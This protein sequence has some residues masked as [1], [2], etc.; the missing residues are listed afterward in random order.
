[1]GHFYLQLRLE[2]NNEVIVSIKYYK[3]RGNISEKF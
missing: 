2:N 1:M 3:I